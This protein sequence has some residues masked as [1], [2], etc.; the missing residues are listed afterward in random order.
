MLTGSLELMSRHIIS[1]SVHL[2]FAVIYALF[3]GF[4]FTIGAELFEIFT[5]HRVYGAEDYMC[6]LTHSPHGAWYQRTPSVWWG[7]IYHFLYFKWLLMCLLVAFL[8]VPMFSLFLSL[9]NRC[10]YNKKELASDIFE[11]G[12]SNLFINI[13]PATPY[14]H[15]KRR[16]GY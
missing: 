11:Y 3:L 4:G 13:H 16:M 2:C 9:R 8:T 15:R 6:S 12:R 7:K 5:G 1:G 14:H 10:P